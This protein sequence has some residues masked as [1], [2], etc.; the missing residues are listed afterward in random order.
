M[1]IPMQLPQFKDQNALL[2]VMGSQRGILYLASDG[3]VEIIGTV[4]QPTARYTDRE[5]FFM[6]SGNGLVYG[7]GSVYEDK[8]I[9]RVRRFFKKAANEIYRVMRAYDVTHVYVFEPTYAKGAVTLALRPLVAD[10]V[11]L[12][13]YGNY[14]HAPATVLMSFIQHAHDSSV[15][16]ADPQSVGN[17]E[18]AEEKRRLLANAMQARSVIGE[19]A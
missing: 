1:Q 5:G 16:P 12:V 19:S 3:R 2:V 8:N 7:S 13:R 17:E 10:R 6:H 14:L 4:E 9:E 18:N 11:E 15:D